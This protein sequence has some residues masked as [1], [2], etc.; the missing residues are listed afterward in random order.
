M[1]TALVALVLFAATPTPTQ[2]HAAKM[3]TQHAQAFLIHIESHDP[4][5]RGATVSL[6]EIGR[7]HTRVR[8]NFPHP[9][10]GYHLGMYQG[11]DC[12]DNRLESM[13]SAIPLNTFSSGQPSSTV[14]NVPISELRSKNYLLA[15]E[16]STQHH[17]AVEA[18]G[19]LN[20]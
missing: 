17:N 20:R 9:Q 18:C 13:R 1:S 4:N 2:V 8:V 15:V 14:V 3:A 12:V 11:S 5:A 7:T 19:H 10:P 6:Q 16:Q